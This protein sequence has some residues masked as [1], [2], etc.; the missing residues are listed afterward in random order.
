MQ[1]TFQTE[2]LFHTLVILK[3]QISFALNLNHEKSIRN[4]F[5]RKDFSQSF[6]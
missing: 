3:N 1:H 5:N 6:G 4:E 2:N